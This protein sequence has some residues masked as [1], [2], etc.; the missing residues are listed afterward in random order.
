MLAVVTLAATTLPGV[1]DHFDRQAVSARWRSFGV[2]G[3]N[4]GNLC[5]WTDSV[6]QNLALIKTD[7]QY[8]LYANGKQSFVFPD[9][10][11][12][13]LRIH[14]IMA[15]NP[16]ARRILVLGG[17]PA[18]DIT[19]LLKYACEE[20]VFVEIDPAVGKLIAPYTGSACSREDPRVRYVN[21]DA[22]RYVARCGEKFDAILVNAPQP[23]SAASGRFYTREF[24]RSVSRLLAPGGFMY[25]ALDVTEGLKLESAKMGASVWNALREV[26]PVVLV[27]GGS[28]VQFFA[29]SRDS[30]LTFDRETLRGR[31]AGSGIRTS[32]FRPE[33]FLG[34][35]EISADKTSYTTS[36][37]AA[38]GVAPNS[39]SRPVACYYS[40]LTWSRVSGSGVEGMLSVA[41]RLNP[42]LISIIV[43]LAGPIL[44]AAGFVIRRKR[45]SGRTA[46]AWSQAMIGLVVLTTGFVGM[47]MEIVLVYMF[48]S[49]QGYVYSRI[50]L[51]VALFMTGLAMGAL[52]GRLLASGSGRRAFLALGVA[53]TALA[54]L[55]VATAWLAVV[56]LKGGGLSGWIIYGLVAATGALA[57]IEFPVAVR[58]SSGQNAGSGQAVAWFNAADHLGAAAGGL[59]AGVLLVPVFGITASCGMLIALKVLSLMGLWGTRQSM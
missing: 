40:L 10:A 44:F 21:L 53:E 8:A 37:F 5:A 12:D 4:R 1:M 42:R 16:S 25:A 43:V 55:F 13:E 31:S 17:N 52:G 26:Y 9:P 58:L 56:L 45:R 48:Q 34:A 18:G 28:R 2:A 7:D 27:T 3:H 49:S 30:G 22:A 20:I 29:G 11:G 33:Y 32:Y 54:V 41:G 59:L 46:D 57:G 14:F 15:Q 24:Y 47:A 6:Y 39:I 23:A 19:E 51:L 38:A 36:R 35:D 50:G